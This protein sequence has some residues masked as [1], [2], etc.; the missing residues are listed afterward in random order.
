MPDDGAGSRYGSGSHQPVFGTQGADLEQRSHKRLTLE[1]VQAALYEHRHGRRPDLVNPLTFNEKVL[2]RK[3]HEKSALFAE[4]SDKVLVR[5][6]VA[7]L[8]GEKYVVPI[9]W[10]GFQLPQRLPASWPENFVLK[11]NYGSGLNRFAAGDAEQ[12]WA[13]LQQDAQKWM[14]GRWPDHLCERWYN[15]IRRRLFIEPLLGAVG[16]PPPDHRFFVFD[17]EV[18]LI[19]RDVRTA[20]GLRRDVHDPSWTRLPVAYDLPFSGL[21]NPPP[22]HLDE[23]L[24]VARTLGRGIDF[25]RIDLYDLE[26]GPVFSEMTFAPG[27]G[28]RPFTP[29]SFDEE[30]GA[31]WQLRMPD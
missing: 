28:M 24:E 21:D 31:R 14:R 26:D 8:V 25:V 3:L 13:S 22:P 18:A 19:V 11:A 23:M 30:L 17:G 27:G 5:E 4:C 9:L 10:Q 16:A 29:A 12:K 20:D 1:E 6:R 15:R 7:Q 2:Y